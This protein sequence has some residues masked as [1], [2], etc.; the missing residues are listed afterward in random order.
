M[1]GACVAERSCLGGAD[2]AEHES[3]N[4]STAH[5]PDQMIVSR[6]SVRAPGLNGSWLNG[7][8]RYLPVSLHWDDPL[9]GNLDGRVCRSH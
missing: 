6:C 2:A 7:D 1:A 5:R 8:V 4:D 9:I 3:K